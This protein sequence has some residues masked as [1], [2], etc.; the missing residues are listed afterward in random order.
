VLIPAFFLGGLSAAI[1]I[2]SLWPELI[3][4]RFWI[5]LST[6]GHDGSQDHSYPTFREV[7]LS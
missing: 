4:A 3:R 1:T 6:W 5:A 2:A 7:H